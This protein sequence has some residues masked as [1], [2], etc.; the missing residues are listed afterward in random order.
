MMQGYALES[1]IRG[2]YVYKSIWHPILGEQLTLEREDGNGHD[3]HTIGVMKGGA[4]IGHVPQE[5]SHAYWYFIS[6]GGTIWCEMTGRRKR[7]NGLEVLLE[8]RSYFR[9]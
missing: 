9:R 7:G 8:M 5:H 2:H 3:R 1:V 6:H 4:I